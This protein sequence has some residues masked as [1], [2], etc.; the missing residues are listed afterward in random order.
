[1]QTSGKNRPHEWSVL[2]PL[3]AVAVAVFT[4]CRMTSTHAQI[5]GT[6]SLTEPLAR[7]DGTPV[8]PY[9]DASQCPPSTD[10]VIWPEGWRSIPNIPREFAVCFVGGQSK[11]NTVRPDIETNAK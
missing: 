11:N 5:T 6:V 2:L 1:M 8:H 7:Q 3:A 10:I 4:V 9:T